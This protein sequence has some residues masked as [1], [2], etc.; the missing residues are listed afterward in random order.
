MRLAAKLVLCAALALA[1]T[2]CIGRGRN[3]AGGGLRAV[4][5]TGAVIVQPAGQAARPLREGDG[6]APGSIVKTGKDARVRLSTDGKQAIEL[7][8][9]TEATIRGAG[10]VSLDRGSALGE[11]G[12]RSLSFDSG[13]IGVQIAS[14]AARLERLLG[15]L[16]VGVYSGAA[17]VSL[18]GR[19]VDVPAYREL[20]FAGGIP[21]ERSPKPLQL[22]AADPWDRRLLGD[23]LELDRELAQFGRGFNSEFG[24]QAAAPVFFVNFVPVP[25]AVATV[26]A[27]PVGTSAADK[28]IGLVFAQQI[29]QRDGNPAHV[30]TLFNA[31]I[32]ERRAG[33]TWGLIAKE[34]GLQLRPLLQAVLGAIR[35]GTAPAS[36]PGSPGSGGG[37]SPPPP[38]PGPTASPRPRPTRS[39]SPSPPASPTPTPTCGPL[40]RL[41]GNCDDAS[42]SSSASGDAGG[43]RC[44]IVGVLLDPKC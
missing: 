9:E 5:V 40:D 39:P 15:T 34:R 32:A 7:A 2:S 18:L 29:A 43:A 14:G 10:G 33:A 36:S 1:G 42:R 38:S 25:Q 17:R 13:G 23:V 28:L 8:P 30:R 21:V 3:D 27:A 4:Q 19:G 12:S 41:L 11:A 22:N 6:I 20:F 37:S 31:L 44:S 24:A 16:R 26:A 35:R